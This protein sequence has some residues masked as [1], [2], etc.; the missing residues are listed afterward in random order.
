MLTRLRIALVAPVAQALPPTRSGSIETLA[1]L[2]ADGLPDRQVL[3]SMDTLKRLWA[4]GLDA[5]PYTP[6]G[7]TKAPHDVPA[8]AL[9]RAGGDWGTFVD[10]HKRD[11]VRRCAAR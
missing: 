1:A 9:G 11:A 7:V 6:R 5:A 10:E 8:F 2:L 4:T 3:R